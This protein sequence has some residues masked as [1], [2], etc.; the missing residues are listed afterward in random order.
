MAID[1]SSDYTVQD[2]QL[3]YM[4]QVGLHL[5]RATGRGQL[6]QV[7]WLYERPIDL[8]GLRRFHQNFGYGMA[9]R[10]IERSPLPF[11]R[12][13]WVSSMGPPGPIH[14]EERARPRSE[15]TA[16]ADERAAV[17]AD[18]EKGPAWH[19]A[20]CPLTDGSTAITHVG[21]HCLGDG[22]AAL[23]AVGEAVL[24]GKRDLGYPLPRSRK[25]FRAVTA[26]LRETV[27]SLPEVGRT[28]VAAGQFAFRHRKEMFDSSRPAGPA[29]PVAHDNTIV[30]MPTA[31][32]FVDVADWDAKADAAH[33][34]N[35]SMLAGIAARLGERMG[36]RRPDGTVNLLIALNDRTSLEDTRAYAMVFAQ[37]D[38]DP[39]AVAEDQADA[40]AAIRQAVKTAREVPDETLQLLPLIPL[41]PERA[42]KGVAEAFF[43]N[44]DNLPVSCSNLGDIDGIVSRPDG[45]DADYTM[46]RAVDQNVR[47]AD[48]ERAGGHL[49]VV[50]GRI[51][52][53]VSIGIEA[54][55]PRAENTKA[56]LREL[57]RQ[58]LADFD[59][60]GEIF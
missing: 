17:H 40:R 48:L 11:G 44:S 16:W 47:R 18:P 27:R 2:N 33:G 25:R 59:L 43:G 19:I 31:S 54:Y 37:V 34:N 3:T 21:T 23:V 12:A 4:D 56:R 5:Y 9:G 41:V 6:M 49:V 55:Q 7:V 24:G 10:L 60:T 50:A 51:N 8:A 39:S 32:A 58:T 22:V 46:V 1:T 53:K 14:F 30:V 36:R 26:D 52:G 28:L 42:L 13:R 15:V 20:V 35:Y 38:V 45:T 29:A 57:I